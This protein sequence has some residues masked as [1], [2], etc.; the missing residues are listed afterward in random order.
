MTHDNH[1]RSLF[2]SLCIIMGFTSTAFQQLYLSSGT[3]VLRPLRDSQC[4]VNV[5]QLSPLKQ[6]A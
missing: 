3:Q 5:S 6:P 2:W 4:D 1:D